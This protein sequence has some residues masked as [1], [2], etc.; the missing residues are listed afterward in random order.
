MY[1][2]ILV[3]EFEKKTD[4]HQPKLSLIFFWFPF[5]TSIA[6]THY[7]LCWCFVELNYRKLKF[8][9]EPLKSIIKTNLMFVIL[10]TADSNIFVSS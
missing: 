2:I 9:N 1:T 6:Q 8:I 3:S 4:N 5:K 10:L 7:K